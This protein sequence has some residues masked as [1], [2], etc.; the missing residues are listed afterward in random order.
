MNEESYAGLASDVTSLSNDLVFAMSRGSKELFHSDVLAWFLEHHPVLQTAL[1]DAWQVPVTDASREPESRVRRE[2]MN[3]DL[4]LQHT[5][6]RPLVIENKVFALPD[7]DQLDT[8]AAGKLHQLDGPFLVLLSLTDP[9]WPEN[10]WPAPHGHI[11]RY[12]S[13]DQL[14]AA[15][16]PCVPSVRRSDEFAGLV[17][18]KWLALVRKLTALVSAFG[19][20]AAAE[21]LLLPGGISAV[22]RRARLDA[23]VQKMRYQYL[24]DRI[25]AALASE[26]VRGELTVKATMSRGQGIV[27]LFTAGPS[28]CFGWQLQEGQ[29]RLVYLTDA[30]PGHGPGTEQRA[31]R[32]AEA[33]EYREYFSFD[34]VREVLGD[35]GPERPVTPA[36]GPLTFNGFAPDFVYRSVPVPALTIEQAVRLAVVQARRA[37][38]ARAA[39]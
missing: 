12:R 32:E 34:E 19:R 8:Y 14:G 31:V 3:L 5:G 21:P 18:E 6:R 15:L 27:E 11:W 30:G 7:T 1:L 36:D 20:P 39:V 13:Y 22:L 23:P 2:W 33:R 26:V 24:A 16:E 17:L 29:F 4:V 10:V 28:P 25:R 35:I 38:S 9:G 37:L